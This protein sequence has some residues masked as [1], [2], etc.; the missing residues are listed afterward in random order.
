[1]MKKLLSILK[2]ALP[3]ALWIYLSRPFFNGQ[4]VILSEN[5]YIYSVLK[6]Y[7]DNITSGVF[8]L[9]NP[10]ITW[11]APTHIYFSYIGVFN[12]V[13]F[14]MPVLNFLGLHIYQSFLIA[15]AFYFLAGQFGFY[16]LARTVLK[17]KLA[18]YTA[19]LLYL[20]SSLSLSVFMQYHPP[21]VYIPSLWF[22]YFL[23]SF[24]QSP[25][26]KFF[27][28]LVVCSM[29]I[30][31]T[32]V[33]FYF[34][35][36][37][38][39]FLIC[40]AAV[41]P[42][43]IAPVWLR[44][45][46]FLRGHRWLAVAGFLAV[47]VSLAP[48]IRAYQSTVTNEIVNP[49]RGEE[50]DVYEKGASLQDYQKTAFGALS[51]RMTWSDC[52]AYLDG[53]LYGDDGFIYISLM[54]YILLAFGAFLDLRRE[55]LV[56]LFMAFVLLLVMLTNVTPVHRFLFEHVFF[57][58][59]IRNMHFFQAYFLAVLIL[60]IAGM[61]GQLVNGRARVLGGKGKA[62]LIT[63]GVHLLF[64]VLL[65]RL[66]N[67]ILSTYIVL[68]LSTIFFLM[69]FVFD[70]P[71]SLLFKTGMIFVLVMIQP[72][73]VIIRHHAKGRESGAF[74]RSV[75]RTPRVRATFAFQRPLS[76]PGE[77]SDWDNN[78]YF[79]WYRMAM[80]DS[81]GF[82]MKKQTGFPLKWSYFIAREIPRR[83]FHQYVR[84]KFYFYD[85]IKILEEGDLPIEEIAAT[86][87]PARN[88]AFVHAE[89]NSEVVR[90]DLEDFTRIQAQDNPL[91][92]PVAGASSDFWIKYF[93]VNSLKFEVNIPRERFL[94][95]T[96][97]YHRNWHCFLDG[98]P[99]PVYR[100]NLAF[101]GILLPAGRHEVYFRY[102]SPLVWS[103]GLILTGL[104][105]ASSAYT[106][107]LF[108]RRNKDNGLRT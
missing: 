65:L 81:P 63:L 23:I 34:L 92:Q 20:F 70:R 72:T 4:N 95:Y 6:Y 30:A 103:L 69:L 83:A 38:L 17:D 5:F 64:A 106:V 67:V 85:Q 35:A 8:P 79:S 2:F 55:M 47:A 9:W 62:I 96:D 80:R 58:K 31:S 94:V 7:F 29:L 97:S 21:L 76:L 53:I 56:C 91:A 15:A 40:G 101:K 105:M 25:R 26:E 27:I 68:I 39:L 46:G 60:P 89:S 41:Y 49:A 99:V 88:P 98:M 84:F 82:F 51:E 50:A 44:T 36:V 104:L 108:I 107:F 52:F 87:R 19:F 42:R 32:Y 93:N 43:Q 48:G 77:E 102:Q 61:Y 73:E 37:F 28:G 16:L 74:I 78:S 10:F 54:A 86:F 22:F 13:W 66:G 3:V 100:T 1:M 59:L 45:C 12:P 18:A 11:G 14:F 24:W 57:F 33:P 71:F 90:A 75:I